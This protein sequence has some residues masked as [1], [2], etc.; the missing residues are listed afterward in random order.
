MGEYMLV[1]QISVVLG[2]DLTA[3]PTIHYRHPG[4]YHEMFP[5]LAYSWT[6]VR[7][8]SPKHVP[9]STKLSKLIQWCVAPVLCRSNHATGPKF[10]LSCEVVGAAAPALLLNLGSIIS[11]RN[12][13]FY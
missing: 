7:A 5:G 9:S 8:Q 11:F 12:I 3:Y 13:F 10:H 6:Y 4:L 2:P 1:C